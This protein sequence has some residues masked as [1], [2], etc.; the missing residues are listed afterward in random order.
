[1][2]SA[3]RMLLLLLL[4][5]TALYV[6]CA[7]AAEPRTE[8]TYKLGEGESPPVASLADASW[9]V[10]AWEGTAFGQHFEE[11][12]NPASANS[13]VGMFKL[14][15]GDEVA[16]YEL[17]LMTVEDGTLSLKVKHFGADFTAWEDK[18]DYVEF[19]LVKIE[20]DALHFSGISFYRR[21][22]DGMNGYIVMRNADGV[23]E[24][25][26]VYRRRD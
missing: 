5:P 12:W 25:P 11:V 7:T 6:N 2:S 23:R 26:L 22:D 14:M 21:G 3:I 15:D 17:L 24:E 1:M 18:P 13:M 16:F 20:A 10:G 9:L 19:R 8:H 4:F